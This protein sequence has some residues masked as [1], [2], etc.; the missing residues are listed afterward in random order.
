LYGKE[1]TITLEEVQTSIR[2][3]ELQ[4]QQDGK[5]ETDNGEGLNVQ[6]GRREKKW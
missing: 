4:R 6:R 3:K 5:S 2:T 1:H